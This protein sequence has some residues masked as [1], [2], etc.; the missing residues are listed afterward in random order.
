MKRRIN[1]F[2]LVFVIVFLLAF[3]LRCILINWTLQY[4]NNVDFVSYEDWARIAHVH[5]F[6]ATYTTPTRHSENFTIPAN[7]QPPGSLYVLSGAYELWITAGKL[8]SRFTHTSVGSIGFVN[9]YL[10]HIFMK[11]PSLLTDLGMGLFAY[12]LVTKEAGRKRGLFVAML[13]LFNPIIFYNSAIWGQMDSINNFLFILSLFFAFRKRII[14]S[15]FAFVASIFVKLSLLPL[16][17]FYLIFLFFLS[18][19]NIKKISLGIALS[20][21]AI[22]FAVLPISSNFTVW[23]LTIMPAITR[24]V[25]QNITAAAFNFWW[26]IL[27]Y[28]SIGHKNIPGLDQIFLIT[29]FRTWAY[30]IFGILSLPFLYFQ[31]KKHREIIS[32]NLIFLIL[33]VIA[34]LIFLF[35]PGMHDR[36]MYPVFP[37]LAIAIGLSR[38]YKPYLIIFCFLSLFNLTN[39][40]YSWYPIVLDSTSTFYH[41]FYGDYFGWIISVLTMPVAGWFYW[42]SLLELKRAK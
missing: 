21:I 38:Q 13:I 22:F 27:C 30:G 4:G 7:N 2:I 18:N 5:N 15:I 24:G 20:A 11:I 34:L 37:L 6:V 10:Q 3:F 26:M 14:P 9:T 12:L 19:K 33:S 28:P 39:I 23:F 31:I 8:I 25:F 29:N 1:R 35:L 41:I 16:L 17:P 36:Y 42:K 40:V 32:K